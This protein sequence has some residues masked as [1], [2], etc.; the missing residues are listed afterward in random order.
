[1]EWDR[2]VIQTGAA[3]ESRAGRLHTMFGDQLPLD[4][5]GAA[6]E[7]EANLVLR[8]GLHL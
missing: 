7:G 1:M 3:G 5:T 2:R 6:Q 8:H 4:I